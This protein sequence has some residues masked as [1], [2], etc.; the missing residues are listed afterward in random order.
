MSRWTRLCHRPPIP[1]RPTIHRLSARRS[2]TLSAPSLEIPTQQRGEKEKE[3]IAHLPKCSIYRWGQA[4]PTP[5]LFRDVDWTWREGEAWAVVGTASSGKGEL[6]DTLLGHHRPL[7]P[8]AQGP[9]PIVSHLPTTAQEHALAYVSFATRPR[10]LG[11]GFY[12]FSARYGAVREEDR[13]TLR[14]SLVEE[15][16]RAG[17]WAGRDSDGDESG[18]STVSPFGTSEGETQSRTVDE[19]ELEEIAHKLDLAHLLDLPLI[20][21][22][23]G[24][25]RRASVLRKLLTKPEV[26]LLD[27]PLTGLDPQHRLSLVSLLHQLH[28]HCAPRILL[29]LRPQDPLPEWVTHVAVVADGQV[30]TGR[31]EEFREELA[32]H[33]VLE[34]AERAVPVSEKSV[35]EGEKEL[36]VDMQGVNVAY[37]ERKVLK[38]IHWQIRA[39]EIWHLRGANGSGKTTLLS[40]LTGDHPQSYTQP[41]LHLFGKPRRQH[42][43]PALQQRIGF[44]SPELY[45]AFPRRLGTGA[46]SGRDAIGSG[47]EATYS[48]RPRTSEQDKII[49]SL[50]EALA[51]EWQITGKGSVL[52]RPFAALN[53]GEQTL[54]LLM[55][56]LVNRP[57]L[58][59]LDEVFAGMDDGMVHRA[60][61]F[62]RE[63]VGEGKGTSV[64]WVSHWEGEMPWSWEKG[65]VRRLSLCNGEA[66]VS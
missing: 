34:K 7:P 35:Q 3:T 44:V 18:A 62:L 64:V 58:L 33:H 61:E 55:R 54:V 31:K 23:N 1:Y 32:R 13:V 57:P 19:R 24:Q 27:E 9:F 47:F 29:A 52:D 6:L 11:A 60:R 42:A 12:D 17:V 65:E 45:N 5:P 2:S 16:E 36:L 22:S 63:Y 49:D 56:A 39:S 66:E 51:P 14:E 40:L 46:L 50:V 30:R 26:L 15:A 43:T 37:H 48:Y 41:H 25:T 8:P 10:A 59:V 53:P 28:T 4:P 21:L 20:A 38:N